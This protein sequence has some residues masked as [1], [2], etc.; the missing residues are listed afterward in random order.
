MSLPKLAYPAIEIPEKYLL[1]CEI[2]FD[3]ETSYKNTAVPIGKE[4]D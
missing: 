1:F 4:G 2:Y 3:T